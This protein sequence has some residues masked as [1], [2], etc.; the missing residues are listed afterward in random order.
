M[1]VRLG[2]LVMVVLFLSSAAACGSSQ[3]V[4][5]TVTPA[6]ALLD[7][8]V[9]GTITGLSPGA[10]TIVTAT[11]TDHAGVVWRST[12]QFTASS[13]GTVRLADP[14]SGGSYTGAAD[15]GLFQMMTPTTSTTD[16]V[17]IEPAG[18]YTVTLTVGVGGHT[19]ASTV[20]RR[21]P[22]EAMGVTERDKRPASDGIYGDLFLPP[23]TTT[24]RPGVLLLGGSE[25]G[26]SSG[27]NASI[28]AAHG[29]PTLALAYFKEP[30]LPPTL[31]NI[32]LEYFVKALNLLAAQ[33][34]VDARHLVVF[35]VSRGSEAALLLGIH[36]PQ[37]VHGVIGGV[38]NSKAGGS[39]PGDGAAWTLGGQPVPYASRH[40]FEDPTP[41]DAPAS[42]FAVEKIN[43]PVLVIC[44]GH[45]AM[46]NSC[47][48]SD[49]I[50]ARL[51]TYHDPFPHQDLKYPLAGHAVGSA[52][53]CYSV[54]DAAYSS[55][56]GTAFA[57]G[58]AS[59][60]AHTELLAYLARLTVG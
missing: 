7:T 29:Y 27:F 46:W 1:R 3:A 42:V 5:F 50:M 40:D 55:L 51:N 53:C 43:G 23:D 11:A 8:P 56:G 39:L 34:G 10:A 25:G 13:A 18:G 33:P 41:A 4:T 48:F 15:L 45:D 14:S 49:A 22:A 60:Q 28:L 16:L 47:D 36:E 52:L 59:E 6:T 30:G 37:L 12:A 17:F 31:Q 32:P 54:L 44:G 9:T 2:L 20:V 24:A 35:G 21:Q 38:P 19:V 26:L 57:N 58:E